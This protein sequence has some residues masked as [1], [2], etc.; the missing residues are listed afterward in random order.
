MIGCLSPSWYRFA[1]TNAPPAMKFDGSMI[2]TRV[3]SPMP[4]GVT[5]SQ[6]APLL[7]DTQTSPSSVP[8]HN[9]P[10]WTGDSSNA[11]INAYVSTPVWSLVIGPP[12]GP[13]VFGSLRARSGDTAAQLCPS[14]VDRKS[15]EPAAYTTLGV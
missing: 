4:G 7:R 8:A 3:K 15:F 12:D 13:M 1:A 11:K 5:F 9:T 6:F 14:F 2:D 10:A